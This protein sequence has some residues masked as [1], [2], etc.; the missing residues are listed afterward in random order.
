MEIIGGLLAA[1][2]LTVLLAG[3]GL[4]AIVGLGVMGVLYFLTEMDFRKVF[5]VSAGVGLLAPILLAVG[6]GSA[7]EDGSFERDLRDEV[8]DFIQLPDDAGDKWREALP[9]LQ[10]ISRANERGDLTDEE[11]EARVKEIFAD[12][13]DLQ[14]GIDVNGDGI[15]IGN[16]DNGVPLELPE[17]VEVDS[18]NSGE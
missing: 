13:E 1:L 8:G 12:F 11:A 4:A 3:V 15:V 14:I 6:I 16:N 18:P 7:L 9:E 5:V 2:V 10:E 17:Q